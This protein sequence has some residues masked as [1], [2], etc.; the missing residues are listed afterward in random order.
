MESLAIRE[1]SVK[2]FCKLFCPSL[3]IHTETIDDIYGPSIVQPN[4]NAIIVSSETEAA[5]S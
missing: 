1:L 5:V 2:E 3:V 4:L